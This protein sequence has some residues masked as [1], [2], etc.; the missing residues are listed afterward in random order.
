ME[1]LDI[2]KML[3]EEDARCVKSRIINGLTP[4]F[5]VRELVCPHTWLRWKTRSWMF[6]QTPLL[7]ALYILRT[8]ILQAPMTVNT[9]RNGGDYDERGLR[10]NMCDIVQSKGALYLS[11]HC[12][13]AAVDFTVRNMSAE[14]AREAIR[15]QWH[16]HSS[17]PIRLE[18]DVN[19]VHL[20]VF[21]G[22]ENI[23]I[24]EFNG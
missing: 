5:D 24:T 3:A 10:C 2:R 9:W 4:Y 14:E 7:A 1:A 16:L 23:L 20:D 22:A 17:I 12:M 6:L 15:T 21:D 18:L 19:W 8:R 13:G 11:P